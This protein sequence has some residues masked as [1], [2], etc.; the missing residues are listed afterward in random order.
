LPRK[1]ILGI[2]PG[3]LKAGYGVIEVENRRVSYIDCGTLVFSSKDLM[4]VRLGQL[5]KHIDELLDEYKPDV[6]ALERAFVHENVA[7]ALK[8]SLSRGVVMAQAGMR[9]ISLSE[10][11]PARVKKV[12][13]GKGSAK[14]NAVKQRVKMICKLDAAP[15]EDAA[16]AVAI[17]ICEGALAS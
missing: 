8:I 5:A 16:D 15:Q 17:A 11:A 9:N 3:T 2:D 14:K 7:S 10:H 4:H 12:V 6:V 13:T 1:R